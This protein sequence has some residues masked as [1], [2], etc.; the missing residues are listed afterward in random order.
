MADTFLMFPQN[1]AYLRGESPKS[2]S[3]YIQTN[4]GCLMLF[5]VPFIMIGVFTI[6]LTVVAFAENWHLENSGQPTT[7]TIIDRTE[8]EDEGST[9][10][11]LHYEYA[12]SGLTYNDNQQVPLEVYIRYAVGQPIDI[13]YAGDSPDVSRIVGV[14]DASLRTFLALFT[15]IWNVLVAIFCASIWGGWDRQ[16]RLH[17][18]GKL[19]RGEIVY[20]DS[21]TDSDGDYMI[22]AEVRF[23][24]P[25]LQP[26]QGKR[27]YT[28]NFH[29]GQPLPRP[30]EAVSILYVDDKLWEIL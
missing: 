12:V 23:R 20:I 29:K 18:Q 4:Y 22:E 10:Y 26:V 3:H 11:R 27:S 21:K 6:A 7:A 14:S 5:M 2:Q 28:S 25:M 30:G 15:L 1:E 24:T 19:V 17:K 9:T 8:D 16:N 13:L